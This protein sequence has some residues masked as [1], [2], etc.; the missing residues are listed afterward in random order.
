MKFTRSKFVVLCQII[1]TWGE[2]VYSKALFDSLVHGVCWYCVSKSL[3]FE[4]INI[5]IS[6]TKLFYIVTSFILKKHKGKISSLIL[7]TKSGT[8]PC[9]QDT[10]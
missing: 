10:Q 4:Y 2:M 8:L 9:C 3:E 5:F 6:F 7:S 1:V